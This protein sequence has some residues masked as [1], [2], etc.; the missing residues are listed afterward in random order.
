MPRSGLRQK[1]LAIAAFTRWTDRLRADL[2]R[3]LR[4]LLAAALR[5][6][7]WLAACFAPRRR[8]LPLVLTAVARLALMLS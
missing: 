7:P 3:A 2:A 5:R 4:H 8:S 1:V 6:R